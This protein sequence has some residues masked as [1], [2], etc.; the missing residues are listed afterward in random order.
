MANKKALNLKRANM[1]KALPEELHLETEPGKCHYDTRVH[2]KPNER[3]VKWIMRYGVQKAV[4][5]EKRGDLMVVIDGRQRVIN[6]REANKRL[7]AKGGQAIE[8]PVVPKRGDVADLF[9]ISI[10]TNEH[11]V[12][13]GPVAQAMKMSHYL[14]MGQ[15]EEE[16]ADLWGVSVQT[17]K[18][19]MVLLEL[20]PKVQ[21]AIVSGDMKVMT[22]MALRDLPFE[23]QEM[24]LAKPEAATGEKPAKVKKIR[25][26][27]KKK[28]AR[29]MA[30]KTDK[31][32]S[33]DV[34]TVIDWLTG[35]ITEEQATARIKGLKAILE[36][37]D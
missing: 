18:N 13:D 6:C 9:R 31:A 4:L 12:Q 28:L 25:K 34:Y 33:R 35:Q 36:A 20:S 11:R 32:F 26:P 16:C 29:V 2:N 3:D 10:I 5:V 21:A 14:N 7:L 24:A 15:T 22:A 23:A 17:V 8:I 19:R 27:T 37:K 30:T 1:F